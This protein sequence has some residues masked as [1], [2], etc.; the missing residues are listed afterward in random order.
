MKK[1]ALKFLLFLLPVMAFNLFLL[2][3]GYM[4][5][6]KD[7]TFLKSLMKQ[8]R[9]TGTYNIGFFGTSR[10][11]NGI[12]PVAFLEGFGRTSGNQPVRAGNFAMDGSK[13]NTTIALA[14]ALHCR[15]DLAV[16]EI[17]QYFPLCFNTGVYL[18]AKLPGQEVDEI[19][20]H[21]L[22]K[23]L[24]VYN[25]GNVLN[26]LTARTG[27]KFTDV[28]PDGW[29]EMYI[30][31]NKTS[32]EKARNN[33]TYFA[34]NG[35]KQP[36][37]PDDILAFARLVRNLTNIHQTQI[38]FL[39]MPTE[40]GVR[41]F[42]EFSLKKNGTLTAL[43]HLFPDALIVHSD[44]LTDLTD[45]KTGEYSHLEGS[46]ARRYSVALGKYLRERVSVE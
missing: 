44:E 42:S 2:K 7:V 6:V 10:M 8:F 12:S 11:D 5:S 17:F 41:Y 38:V 31:P 37:T 39:I 20:N 33:W 16:I 43:R 29:T 22:Y 4:F 21:S 40:A 26:E 1:F 9:E 14:T 24:P 28:H 45:F 19:V 35:L 27:Y 3:A 13:S 46:E 15:L 18:K 23:F 34:I 25:L 32:R 36:Q 30:S